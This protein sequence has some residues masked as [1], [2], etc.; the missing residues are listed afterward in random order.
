MSANPYKTFGLS[1]PNGGDFH[2]CEN[3]K[4]EFIGC[5]TTDPCADGSGLCDK[6]NLRAASFSA[7]SY[8]DI[9]PQSCETNGAAEH[10]YTC[11]ANEPPFLGCCTI[12]PCINMTC[13][14][15][16]LRAAI[17]S[18]DHDSRASFLAPASNGGKDT[19]TAKSSSNGLSPG[20]VAG[21]VVTIVLLLMLIT[22]VVL[23][24]RRGWNLFKP[25]KPK[26]HDSLSSASANDVLMG[27]PKSLGSGHTTSST[28]SPYSQVASPHSMLYSSAS[29]PPV[30][31]YQQLEPAGHQNSP[32][33][34]WYA[35]QTTQPPPPTFQFRRNDSGTW[36][37]QSSTDQV[38]HSPSP[39]PPQTSAW[40]SRQSV[41]ELLAEVQRSRPELP[42]ME[43]VQELRSSCVVQPLR[44]PPPPLKARVS[45]AAPDSPTLGGP[46]LR[47]D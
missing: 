14:S 44:P 43:R 24:R 1:C 18:S 7:S 37:F 34:Q 40:P 39:K 22:G 2:I 35:Q 19:A 16:N 31:P 10:F 13:P 32:H 38:H 21:I 36:S 28:F 46:S 15:A 41:H 4:K 8:L 45:D 30:A 5:C 26:D 9:P 29:G 33:E 23:W 12:N 47:T 11:K 3:T 27:S 42:A 6:M 25:A 20:A 17:L